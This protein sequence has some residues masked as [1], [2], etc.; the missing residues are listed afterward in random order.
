MEKKLVSTGRLRLN[1]ERGY[2]A[3]Q[4]NEAAGAPLEDALNQVFAY[5][6]GCVIRSREREREREIEREKEEVRRLQMEEMER[7]RK[8]E[9]QRRAEETRKREELLQQAV[10]LDKAESIRRLV[11]T[12]EGRFV[13][14]G[15]SMEKF[16]SWRAWALEVAAVQDPIDRLI[17][18]FQIRQDDQVG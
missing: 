4:V 16:A 6:Y 8:A 12:L 1:I 18:L 15:E 9:A 14:G 5:G 10:G 17:E 13:G 2:A 7:Q 3:Y 11:A